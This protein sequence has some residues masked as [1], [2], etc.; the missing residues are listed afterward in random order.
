MP[1]RRTHFARGLLFGKVPKFTSMSPSAMPCLAALVTTGVGLQQPKNIS[2]RI[3][4]AGCQNSCEHIQLEGRPSGPADQPTSPEM[5]R[6]FEEK[7]RSFWSWAGLFD[8]KGAPTRKAVGCLVAG[9]VVGGLVNGLI[10]AF[11]PHRIVGGDL[12]SCTP[13]AIVSWLIRE[14]CY[15]QCS[16]VEYLNSYF[17]GFKIEGIFGGFVMTQL[18]SLLALSAQVPTPKGVLGIVSFWIYALCILL[19]SVFTLAALIPFYSSYTNAIGS[20][21]DCF[22]L[23]SGS[24]W[25]LFSAS[26]VFSSAFHPFVL[27]NLNL[28]LVG[29]IPA[30]H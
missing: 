12:T 20:S 10:V 11:S 9:V 25:T 22:V 14:Q 16:L 18:M 30:C 19:Q 13:N 3:P 27:M 1:I 28:I 24:N 7:K 5:F 4:A 8:D 23:A 15:T 26:F 29:R 21:N 17:D 2:R 6:M